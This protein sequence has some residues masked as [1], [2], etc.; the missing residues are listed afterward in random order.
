[1]YL[2]MRRFP[3]AINFEIIA[4]PATANKMAPWTLCLDRF[5]FRVLLMAQRPQHVFRPTPSSKALSLPQ[6]RVDRRRCTG[7]GAW[8]PVSYS[9]GI[10]LQST[11]TDSGSG[12]SSNS[13]SN[14]DNSDNKR[15]RRRVAAEQGVVLLSRQNSTQLI[16]HFSLI[17]PT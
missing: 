1:M 4:F 10:Y 6:L 14:S 3:L 8:A 2:H 7:R 5:R 11:A 13:G 17:I 15:D 16:N 9:G 12:S